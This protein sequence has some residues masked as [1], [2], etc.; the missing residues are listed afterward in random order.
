MIAA[1]FF[2]HR[3]LRRSK[4]LLAMTE[5]LLF[6]SIILFLP[7]QLGLHFWPEYS[8]VLGLRI[9]YLSPTIYMTDVLILLLIVLWLIDSF[10]SLRGVSWWRS[11]LIPVILNLSFD[12]AQALSLPNG[13]QNLLRL[14]RRPA[15]FLTPRND[16]CYFI[17]FLSLGTGI[18]FSKFPQLGLYGFIKLLELIFFG[19]YTAL[20]FRFSNNRLITLFSIGV[21]FESFLATAQYLHQGSLQGIFYFFGER[22]FNPQT[23]GIANASLNGALVL[24]PYGTFSHPNVLA[25]YLLIVL[26]MLLNTHTRS[27]IVEKRSLTSFGMTSIVTFG[28]VAL[29]L[30]MSRTA[31][32]L[33]ILIF[34]YRLIVQ[35]RTKIKTYWLIGLFAFLLF[36]LFFF[37]LFSRFSIQLSDESIVYRTELNKAA[38]SIFRNHPLFGVGL[39][40]F[41]IN[42][43]DYISSNTKTILLQ[44]VHNIYLLLLAET[45]IV[46]FTFFIW[47]I[48][49]AVRHSGL[50]RFNRGAP[51]ATLL[52]TILIIGLFD[53]YFLTLQQGQL[54]FSFI[55]GLCYNKN[56]GY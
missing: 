54:L 44:P 31:V 16:I 46:G 30:T 13:I 26:Q 55:L 14:L 34:A 32:L 8:K 28:S 18:V 24:R 50:S 36:G 43:P 2:E 35:L 11:N 1:I 7:T 51:G 4:E 40:N 41:L 53:H 37:P 19:Y 48:L 56:N 3:L 17:F 39:N 15:L 49:N 47:F 21:V 5:L 27:V 12:S 38:L 6:Y 9:D 10:L 45:G 23:P 42:L 20:K 22:F 29:F 52:F 25:G 33:Y